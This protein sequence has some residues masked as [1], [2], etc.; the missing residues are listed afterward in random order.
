MSKA[1][2]AS[3]DRPD[4]VRN[5]DHGRIDLV[6]LGEESIGRQVLEPGWRWSD[7]VKPVVGTPTCEFHHFGLVLSG[8]L[9][10][11]MADGTVMEVG[12]DSVYEIPPGH[13]AWVVGDEPWIGVNWSGIRTWG[14]P[15]LA[16]GE[17]VL[18][19]VLF[20]DI[21][22]S[23]DVAARIGDSR[24]RTLLAS[25]NDQVRRALGRFSGVEVK[26][27]GDGFL[28]RFDA[29]ARALRCA[30]AIQTEA[31]ALD[32]QIRA[33]VHTG[34][35]EVVGDDIRGLAVHFASRILGL[36]RPG[37]IVTSA[38]TRDLVDGSG[39][40]FEDRGRHE[41]KGIAGAREVL[42]LA[43]G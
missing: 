28:A 32:L 1:Q 11:E 35:V 27:T 20:T 10:V 8:R 37:D 22:G 17:R 5:L 4:E 14:A 7:H 29:P 12:P 2:W 41:L 25:H 19:T 6:N 23:T 40:V 18:T 26:T 34:E 3:F 9:H 21:V 43:E 36:A 31:A 42:A 16:T 33:A 30:R 15:L 39:L 38:T 13:D 24:W